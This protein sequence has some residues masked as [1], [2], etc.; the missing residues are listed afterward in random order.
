MTARHAE[1]AGWPDPQAEAMRLALAIV[2]SIALN[3]T[4]FSILPAP[5]RFAPTRPQ[6]LEVVLAPAKPMH[7]TPA[8]AKPVTAAAEHPEAVQAARP[9]SHPVPPPVLRPRHR[10]ESS[11]AVAPPVRHPHHR[12]ERSAA[13]ALERHAATQS[14]TATT[15]PPAQPLQESPEPNSTPAAAVIES[16]GPSLEVAEAP[17]RAPSAL[18]L[19]NYGRALSELLARHRQYPPLARLRGWEGAVALRLEIAPQGELIEAT[20]QHS[21]GHEILDQTALA[22][23]KSLSRLP[24]P[25]GGSDDRPLAVQ[26][27]VVFELA[28][29]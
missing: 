18:E 15:P 26:V 16:P 11:Q 21:S 3:L 28:P 19:S 20:V 10:T 5:S 9:V 23:A 25:P 1:T 24:P 6:M 4:V 8:A 17:E 22:M 29:P 2:L 13:L 12:A 27:D 7:P 14:A